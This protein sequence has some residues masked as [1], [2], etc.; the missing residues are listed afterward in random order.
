MPT[1]QSRAIGLTLL[2]LTDIFGQKDRS[3]RMKAIADLWVPS[4]EVL[5]IDALGVFKSHEAISEMVEKIQSMSG[6]GDEFVALGEVDCLK[7]DD[8]DDIWVTKVK[9]GIK[10]ASSGETG[11]TGEDVVTIAG[12]KI[13]A[14]YTFLDPK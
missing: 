8:K 9:W 13:K 3:T 7:H 1:P 12:G 6:E 14:C 11:L 4:S 10:A 5:F 2:N